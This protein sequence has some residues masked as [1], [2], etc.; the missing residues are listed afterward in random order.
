MDG[1]TPNSRYD[2]SVYFGPACDVD[3]T[4]VVGMVGET[5]R[6]AKKLSLAS[7]V[8]LV[9]DAAVQ[10]GARSVAWVDGD[11]L[12]TG[13]PA[14][15]FDEG[16]KLIKRPPAV[17]RSLVFSNRCP[18][19][20]SLEVFKGNAAC[21]VFGLC[22]DTLA[23]GVVHDVAESSLLARETLEVPFRRLGANTLQS[24]AEFVLPF[25]NGFDAST[26][27]SLTIGIHGEIADAKINTEPVSRFDGRAI[28]YFD[29]NV[30]KELAIAVDEI[31]LTSHT[32]ETG[33][34]ID[35]DD[36]GQS[37]TTVQ[38]GNTHA[39]NT[40]LECV[41][42][43]VEGDRAVWFEGDAFGFVPFVDLANLRD[44]ADGVLSVQAETLSNL[45][46]VEMLKLEFV[47]GTKLESSFGKPIAS[48]ID[49][50]QSGEQSHFFLASN[51]HLASCH[52]FHY[53]KPNTSKTAVKQERQH[54]L[55]ALKDGASMLEIR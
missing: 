34:M 54:F 35:S 20:D 53:L 17:H 42:S 13:K 51:N 24:S 38:G 21:G 55:P 52:E 44:H 14:F 26:A 5:A 22:D 4:D 12:N 27:V 32:F 16:T 33:T 46:V 15:V 18:L 2:R 23:D 31:S 36:N 47:G 28:G 50:L 9:D 49:A 10:A 40:V 37:Q 8:R 45:V 41:E 19:A 48:R 6:L 11:N 1:F 3:R 39:V 30:E 29:R 7:A 43:L 25:A